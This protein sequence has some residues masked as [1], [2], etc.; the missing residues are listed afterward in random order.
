[1]NDFEE[2]IFIKH[3][4]IRKIKEQLYKLGAVY[5]SMSGSGSAV[6]GILNSRPTYTCTSGALRS[7]KADSELSFASSPAPLFMTELNRSLNRVP[8]CRLP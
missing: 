3:P 1:M 2:T 5:A 6:F 7:G 4:S 8:V